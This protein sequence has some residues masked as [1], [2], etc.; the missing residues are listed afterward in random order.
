MKEI[1]VIDA[2]IPKIE[3]LVKFPKRF[4]RISLKIPECV[5]K[6]EEQMPVFDWRLQ[7]LDFRFANKIKMQS[8][9]CNL[10]SKI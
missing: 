10:K 1:E 8:T 2:F 4:P 6:I 9:I 3:R 5:I 7:I